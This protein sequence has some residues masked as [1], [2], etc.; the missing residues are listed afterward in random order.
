[1]RTDNA[2]AVTY[3]NQEVACPVAQ[4]QLS[5][6]VF[7][8]VV[9]LPQVPLDTSTCIRATSASQQHCHRQ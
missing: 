6:S 4:C 5:T 1:M 3:L 2:V 7:I 9:V 8:A